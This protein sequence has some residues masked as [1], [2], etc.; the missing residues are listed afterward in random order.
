MHTP[1]GSKKCHRYFCDTVTNV[2][3]L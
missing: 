3:Q 2:D 1:C